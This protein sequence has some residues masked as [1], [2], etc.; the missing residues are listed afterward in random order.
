MSKYVTNFQ[1][2]SENILIKDENA[3]PNNPTDIAN[4]VT[5]IIE[6]VVDVEYIAKKMKPVVPRKVSASQI[7]N[8]LVSDESGKWYMQGGDYIA[9]N[10]IVFAL[11]DG[12]SDSDNNVKLVKLNT[13]THTV[14]D[15]NTITAYHAN[16]VCYNPLTGK[17]YINAYYDHTNPSTWVDTIFVV[18]PNTLE[19]E[20]TVHPTLAQSAQGVYSMA[21]DKTTGKWYVLENIGTTEGL[22]NRVVVYS[23]STFST[24]E[25]YI[26]LDNYP[27]S[28]NGVV[29]DSQGVMCVHENIMYA[30]VYSMPTTIVAYNMD[31]E[32]VGKYVVDTL[33]QYMPIT[34]AECLFYHEGL[35]NLV[36]GAMSEV[37]SGS[38]SY[39]WYETF[40][41]V[42]ILN[43]VVEWLPIYRENLQP[44]NA[45]VYLS[46][47]DV[48]GWWCETT[49]F[50]TI[51][52][53]CAAL[54][55][56]NPG[57]PCGTINNNR[58]SAID[59]VTI[60][61]FHGKIKGGTINGVVCVD[62]DV[63]FEDVTILPSG[64]YV[65]DN[66][67]A[68]L[69]AVRSNIILSGTTTVNNAGGTGNVTNAVALTYG[70]KLSGMEKVTGNKYL[71]DS[72]MLPEERQTKAN[73]SADCN[74]VLGVESTI[75]VG[76]L[77]TGETYDISPTNHMA[78]NNLN[79]K[80]HD[81]IGRAY[82]RKDDSTQTYIVMLPAY[83]SEDDNTISYKAIVLEINW[84]TSKMTVGQIQSFSISESTVTSG[85]TIS[86]T[87]SISVS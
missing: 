68:S 29:K 18:N 54:S 83:Y 61:G 15:D 67:V 76:S 39:W 4:A 42:G 53:A 74:H 30:L 36:M 8:K 45:N 81:G 43:E 75:Y 57:R 19:I 12:T 51:E 78:F 80:Y 71:T 82:I 79:V 24:I 77:V 66:I 40:S 62:S 32:C 44:Q 35:G 48:S 86:G 7:A 6:D 1:I 52:A 11:K 23:D 49:V 69:V 47:T 13:E 33:N 55:L 84:L 60:S 34:E 87:F 21:V 38:D 64:K 46:D 2:G 5:P 3:L 70:S 63:V 56:A 65:S 50:K 31:G 16:S 72:I 73:Y 26:M 27:Y 41:E 59:T 9:E 17:I 58:T 10:V 22:S 20:T 14:L 28:I 37:S 85:N 25:K